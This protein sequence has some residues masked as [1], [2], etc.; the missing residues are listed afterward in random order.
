MASIFDDLLTS[1][2]DITSLLGSIEGIADPDL[3]GL[4]GDTQYCSEQMVNV[5]MEKLIQQFE[6]EVRRLITMMNEMFSFAGALPASNIGLTVGF[7]LDQRYDIINNAY[8]AAV[9]RYA[10]FTGLLDDESDA[11]DNRIAAIGEKIDRLLNR[12]ITVACRTRTVL[13]L[14]YAYIS[15][16]MPKPHF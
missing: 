2:N 7:P 3:T 11:I 16:V 14:W 1:A 15:D 4:S 13:D 6:D 12:C 10:E 9:D 5:K 8:V